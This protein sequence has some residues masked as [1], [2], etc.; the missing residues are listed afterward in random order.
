MAH[1]VIF[2]C[3]VSP[4]NALLAVKGWWQTAG[5]HRV[6]DVM[7]GHVADAVFDWFHGRV[8]AR[9]LDIRAKINGC[10]VIYAPYWMYTARV[11]GILG[12]YYYDYDEKIPVKRE[13]DKEYVWTSVATDN[14]EI[15]V[16]FLRNRDGM[17]IPCFDNQRAIYPATISMQDAYNKGHKA[18]S[19]A[20]VKFAGVKE[21]ILR[22]INT[23]SL[24]LT[25]IY[26]PLWI[27]DYAFGKD[28]YQATV[29]GVTGKVISG[30]APGDFPMRLVAFL[31]GVLIDLALVAWNVFLLISW[32]L[33]LCCGFIVLFGE[34]IE[35]GAVIFTADGL[36]YFFY[37][38]EVTTGDAKGGYRPA[39]NARSIRSVMAF[40]SLPIIFVVQNYFGY[41]AAKTGGHWLTVLLFIFVTIMFILAS[42]ILYD[43]TWVKD[44]DVLEVA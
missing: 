27:V 18:I 36:S 22:Q 25:L 39:G 24:N 29:D 13:I 35:L 20:A 30:S 42:R 2:K 19:E 21:I 38:I 32:N 28:S 31:T 3:D 44:A 9:D 43:N 6:A 11:T 40:I 10:K 4:E 41:M 34:I 15:T 16:K 26:Y 23:T 17:A 12:G 8:I 14:D 1:E 33:Y 37:G 5:C 7:Q